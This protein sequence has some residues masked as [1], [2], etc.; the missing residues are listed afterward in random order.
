MMPREAGLLEVDAVARAEAE[1]V[2]EWFADAVRTGALALPRPGSGRTLERWSALAALGAQDPVRAR[3]GEGHA[4]ALAVLAELDG[5]APGAQLWGVWAARPDSVRAWPGSEGWELTGDRPWCSGA[6]MCTRALVTARAPDG[7]RL[8]VVDPRARGAQPVDGSWPAVGMAASD[9]RT[10]CFDRAP[11][12][13]VGQ[14]GDYTAR[15]GFSHGGIGVAACWYGGAVGVAARLLA[16]VR[17][18]L[19]DPFAAA[20]LG[21]VDA[22]LSAA[23]AALRE[24]AAVLDARPDEPHALLTARVRALVEAAARTT[25][26]A[27][28]RA[29]GAEPLGHD[30]RHAR[31]VADLT[32]YLRQSHAERD[33][34]DLGRAVAAEL[35]EP[36]WL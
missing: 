16:E 1:A 36:W 25:L 7:V 18:G 12:V 24:A 34:A 23:A 2:A 27:V 8:F 9:T 22:A 15:P 32:V 5:P 13:A 35:G 29:L 19:D 31:R 10:V 26:D 4:D 11:A 14:P 21:A 28:G 20:H 33:L 17:A 3:L 6:G 30:R